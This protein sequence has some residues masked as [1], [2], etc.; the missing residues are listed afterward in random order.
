M[1]AACSTP[2]LHVRPS[3][4][5]T[6]LLHVRPSNPALACDAWSSGLDAV[7]AAAATTA[8][9]VALLVVW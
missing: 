2:L 3:S 1:Q 8:C 9:C 6:P 7:A 4:S 5:R